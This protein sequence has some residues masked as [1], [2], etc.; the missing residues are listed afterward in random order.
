MN[1][2]AQ[3]CAI[4]V[5][6]SALAS[7][8][9]AAEVAPAQDAEIARWHKN[10]DR[11]YAQ[12]KPKEAAAELEKILEADGRNFEAL[13][14]LARAYI[15]IGDMIGESGANWKERKLKD[16]NT[17]EDYARRAV[18]I[19]PN[20]TWGHFWVAAALGNA[21][22]VSPVARQLELAPE[23]RAGI[24]KA[25]SLDPNNGLAYHAYGVWHRKVAEIGGT[26]RMLAPVLYGQSVP[27]ASLDKS[28]EYLKKA[29]E[30]NPTIIVS[31]LELARSHVA[32]EEWEPA[33]A[34]LRSVGE[35]P[36]RFSDDGKHKKQAAQLLVQI[37]ER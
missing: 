8:A 29:V 5:L 30:L 1:L 36:I 6:L 15:D 11:L 25:I 34:L 37:S 20:S 27:A 14:K 18:R 13:I 32:K 12:F 23:I 7:V 16:Y 4:G 9:G 2:L 35:L 10:A 3:F 21:A 28:I 26:S 22:M 33:R 24:E 31:R 19:N 17:A